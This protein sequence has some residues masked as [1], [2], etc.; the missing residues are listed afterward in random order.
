MKTINL[1]EQSETL[2]PSVATIGFFD[3]VH[4][5][6]CHIINKVVA[7]AREAG[8]LSTVVTFERHPRQV[9]CSDWHPQLLSSLDEKIA[10]LSKTGIDQLAILHFDASMA[11]LSAHD[12]MADVLL[13]QL[14]V[15]K[16][17]IGYDNHFG[18][19]APDSSEGFDDYV[20]YGHELG[21]NVVQGDPIDI[22]EVRVSSSKVRRLL[23]EGNVEK[24]SLCLGRPYQLQGLIVRGEHIGTGLGFPTANLQLDDADMLIPSP[25]AYAVNV[26]VEGS[27][28][29]KHGMMNIGRR[30]TFDGN[31]LTLETHIF[32]FNEDIY[33]KRM[34]VWFISRLRSEMRFD[35]GEALA[36]QLEADARHAE[37]ILKA[38]TEI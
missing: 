2:P 37:E 4:L 20:R 28:D 12:F 34:R 18:H 29:I 13:R 5:G 6:H 32:H 35:N 14:N 1:K 27:S 19:R 8:L 16:L 3:G 36:A 21:L 23:A 17:V 26:L 9:L 22:G 24:A 25:G 38:T 11:A 15:R 7:M 30:P 10:L 33:G 31:H